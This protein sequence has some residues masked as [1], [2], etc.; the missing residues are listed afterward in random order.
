MS[1]VH[2]VPV[3]NLHLTAFKRTRNKE[4]GSVWG[5]RKNSQDGKRDWF[6]DR[7]K[8]FPRR[9]KRWEFLATH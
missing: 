1:V 2:K 8:N 4:R 3:F 9:W 6:K 7:N 5:G